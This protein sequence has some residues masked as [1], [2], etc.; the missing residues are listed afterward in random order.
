MVV[1]VEV[2][3]VVVVV[4]S[5]VFS[6]RVVQSRFRFLSTHKLAVSFL[7]ILFSRVNHRFVKLKSVLK[8]VYVYLV[9]NEHF[10]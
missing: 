3:V 1:G 10:R 8:V 6:I 2:L 5:A 4:R 9:F 7:R